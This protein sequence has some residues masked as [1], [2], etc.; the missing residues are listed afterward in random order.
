MEDNIYTVVE[1][2]LQCSNCKEIKPVTAY[3][4]DNRPKAIRN[5]Y[6][7]NYRCKAC[8][9]VD[10]KMPERL[11][12]RRDDVKNFVVRLKISKPGEYE[13]R[14]R[15]SSLKKLYGLSVEQYDTMLIAQN[16][17]C[18]GCGS[19]KPFGNCKHFCV[20][21]DHKTGLVRGLL[22]HKCNRGLGLAKDD[23]IVLSE[24]IKY[25]NYHK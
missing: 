5:R 11:L 4:I 3:T 18:A 17:V 10:R 25:L 22:C 8:H 23:I 7:R 9:V 1:P 19:D 16:G 12:K 6:G 24:M 15:K 14:Q 20:D 2:T 13:Y 21:H